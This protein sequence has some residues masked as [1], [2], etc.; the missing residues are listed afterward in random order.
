MV[1]GDDR[2]D[3]RARAGNGGEVMTEQHDRLAGNVIDTV[4]LRYRGSFV[5]G[6][7]LNHVAVD[8]RGVKPVA[9]EI[10]KQAGKNEYDQRPHSFSA[11]RT[12]P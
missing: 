4:V 5:T 11:R 2:T 12:A 7:G 9:H 8:P 6:V 10:K 1:H 3:D